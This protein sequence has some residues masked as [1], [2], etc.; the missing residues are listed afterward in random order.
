MKRDRAYGKVTEKLRG[1]VSQAAEGAGEVVSGAVDRAQLL[2]EQSRN[3]V[4][5][6][7]DQN[8]DGKVDIEDIVAAGLRVP[9]I[10]VDREEFLRR[11]LFKRYPRAVIEIAVAQNPA[12]AGIPVEE[13]DPIADEVIEFERRCVSGI[14][15]ALGSPGGAVMA[16]T[17]P[18]DIMQYYGYMLRAA[19]KLLYLYGFPEID[20][21]T[22]GGR[23][24]AETMNLLILCLGAM[25]GVAGVNQALHAV[26]GALAKGVE[27]KLLRAALTKG[28][29]YPFV[30]KT[31]VWFGVAMN[32]Q[33]F[34]GFFRKA[35][36]V[37]G[38]VL[39]GGITYLSF[40][41]CCEKLKGSLR[42]TMLSDPSN[43][44]AEETSG[45]VIEVLEQEV[46]PVPE[47]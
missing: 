32:K 25:Y 9:G 5:G 22:E 26:A 19:Q 20:V 8:G 27:K 17:I 10:R 35:I 42:D 21:E 1:V 33:I 11:E 7:L 30:K 28:T 47:E 24:D 45:P 12:A 16:V 38:G 36:P 44:G 6:A 39:G 31:A 46:H 14:S 34:A 41:P 4:V 37:V 13:M 15:A 2:A 29:I 40:K 3:T 43:C 18:A 23:L